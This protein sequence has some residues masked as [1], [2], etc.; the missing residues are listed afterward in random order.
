MKVFVSWSGERSMLVATALRNYLPVVIQAVEPWFSGTDIQ[1]GERWATN[2]E[3]ALRRSEFAII[4]VTPEN[5]GSSWIQY[6]IG[7]LSATLGAVKVCP[8][9]VGFRPSDL[10]GPLMQFQAVEATKDGTWRLILALNQLLEANSLAEDTLRSAFEIWWPRL[11]RDIADVLAQRPAAEAARFAEQ[12][13]RSDRDLLEEILQRLSASPSSPTP[14]PASP[15]E[16][17]FVFLVHGRAEGTAEMIAR[18]VEKL[19]PKVVILHEQANEGR[20]VIE[21]F[22]D[23]ADVPFAIV[24]MTGDDR[25]G[26]NGDDIAKQ[27][28][29][30]RQNVVFELGYFLAKLGRRYVAV[31]HEENVELPSDYSGVVYL[32]L[33]AAGAW[34]WGLAREIRAAG[35]QVDLNNAL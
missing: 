27:Q 33:D 22:E 35:L 2:I 11:E 34:R 14:S 24:L 21:K 23:H 28:V 5:V 13:S 20:T 1:P 8:Y 26:L 30:A 25:G 12:I 29:R 9:L 6:E 7:A 19:G 17:K 10:T 15:A 31:V 32:P 18:F 16:A 4:C 3:Y